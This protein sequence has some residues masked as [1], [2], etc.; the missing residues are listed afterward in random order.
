M[1]VQQQD[2]WTESSMADPQRDLS[3]VNRVEYKAV[4]HLALA[5]P[6]RIPQ[7]P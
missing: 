3:D 7:E 6:V 2:G 1:P 4:E 5:H